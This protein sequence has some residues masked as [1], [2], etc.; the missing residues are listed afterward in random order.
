[1][2]LLMSLGEGVKK[3]D[4]GREIER[5]NRERGEREMM[6]DQ[7]IAHTVWRLLLSLF[8]SVLFQHSKR[9][10]DFQR[11]RV[12]RFNEVDDLL[13]KVRVE[14]H[15]GDFAGQVWL[16]GV[17]QWVQFLAKNEFLLISWQLHKQNNNGE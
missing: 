5:E 15:A 4:R 12:W 17:D 10:F 7:Q 11:Q 2:G 13:G 6:R 16:T 3:R 9:L 1:M 14:Q 8:G